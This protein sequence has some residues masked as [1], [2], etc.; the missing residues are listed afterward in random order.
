M[1]S[2]YTREHRSN[3]YQWLMLE[4]VIGDSNFAQFSN[5]CS[6]EHR[7][8]PWEYDEK[9]LDLEEKLKE[10]FWMLVRA[11]LTPRQLEIYKLIL[12]G[13][14]QVEIGKELGISQS[15]VTKCLN[16]SCIYLEDGKTAVYGGIIIKMQKIIKD[17][18]ELKEILGQINEIRNEKI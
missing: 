5:K 8:N 2:N 10:V 6:I 3:K 9:L 16:G 14:T 4:I 7:L 1:S 13:L 15:T 12:E 11:N 17:N 18:I